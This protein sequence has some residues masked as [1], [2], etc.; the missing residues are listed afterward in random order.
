MHQRRIAPP[1]P[2]QALGEAVEA[3]AVVVVQLRL[4]A[5]M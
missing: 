4:L 2:A 3:A 5:V 1:F